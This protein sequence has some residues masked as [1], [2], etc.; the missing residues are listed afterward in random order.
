VAV[1]TPLVTL[2]AALSVRALNNGRFSAVP[3]A[4][5]GFSTL[6]RAD[7]AVIYVAMLAFHVLTDPQHR[8]QHLLWG[9]GLLI[10]FL[11]AQTLFRLWYYGYPA[12]NTYY[13]KMEGDSLLRRVSQGV[14]STLLATV[15]SP[16]YVLP[17]AVL[18]LRRDRPV[19]LLLFMALA[20]IA[21]NVY[22]GGDSLDLNGG[23]TRFVAVIVPLLFVLF[24][25]TVAQCTLLLR[26]HLRAT[27]RFDVIGRTLLHYGLIIFAA[28]SLISFNTLLTGLDGYTQL[29]LV[30]PPAAA[31]VHRQLVAQ[32][33]IVERITLPDA[34]VAVTFAGIIPYYSGRVGVDILGKNDVRIAHQPMHPTGAYYPGHMK[35]DYAYTYGE[36]KPDVVAQLWREDREAQLALLE[37]EYTSVTING[38]TMY[39]RNE[40]PRVRWDVVAALQTE[41]TQRNIRGY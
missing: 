38:Y 18:L 15:N 39:L 13:L 4:L 19:V 32:A 37:G 21:Y 14:I 27:G 6:F 10:G 34:T 33:R 26:D 17:F 11:A 1:L 24:W 41:T 25:Q 12:P 31:T 30:N 20:Q 22:V 29:L 2:A 28:L 7:M 9:M 3:Y 35:Y 40:S 16:V 8:R 23:A 36:I 5:L